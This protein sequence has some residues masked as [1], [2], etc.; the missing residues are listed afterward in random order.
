LKLA[1]GGQAVIEGV[2]MRGPG[3]MVVA[4][5][6]PDGGIVVR[7]DRWVPLLSRYPALKLPLIR[8][9]AM[10]VESVVNGMQALSWSAEA[11]MANE[12]ADGRDKKPSAALTQGAI[13]LSLIGSL[14]IGAGMFILLPHF[15]ATVLWNLGAG[16]PLMSEAPVDKALFHTV[17][18]AVKMTVFVSYILLI[19]RLPDI[20]RVF[21]YHG[22]EHKSIHAYEAGQDLT[23]ENAKS[24][25]TFHPRC[26]TS[27]LVFVI[28]V[29]IGFFSAV[30]PFLP[31]PDGLIGWQ[32]N[33]LQAAIKLPLMIPIAGIAYE[34]IKFAG[35]LPKGSALLSFVSWPGW[36][37]QQLTTIEPDEPQ[38]EVAL[39]SLKRA[40]EHEGALQPEWSGVR[41]LAA[42]QPA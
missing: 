36:L 19:R 5:R 7:D 42:P 35:K 8:G 34:I 15:V 2:M 39:A 16:L 26:G 18:G 9:A 40:L 29:S 30:F 14:A 41:F 11:A 20:R 23:V 10:L 32:L 37:V 22:A 28:L 4:V 6:A 12:S 17:V 25:P 27:L 21:Q 13:A 24:W 3:S 33:L 1:V 31:R 38:L